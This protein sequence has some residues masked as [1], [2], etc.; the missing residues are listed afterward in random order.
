MAKTYYKQLQ[1]EV[2]KLCGVM[3]AELGLKSQMAKR[4]V[5]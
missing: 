5:F 2:A 3:A 1:K 4:A